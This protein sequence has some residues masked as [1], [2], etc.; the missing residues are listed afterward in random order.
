MLNSEMRSANPVS[1]SRESAPRSSRWV[2]DA[3]YEMEVCSSDT[4]LSLVRLGNVDLNSRKFRGQVRPI[5]YSDTDKA[6]EL[7]RQRKLV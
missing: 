2:K 4:T 3:G 7:W 5:V 6:N 1:R